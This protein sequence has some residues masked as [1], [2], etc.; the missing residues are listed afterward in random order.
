MKA[1][2]V[3]SLPPYDP[4]SGG[5]RVMHYLAFVLHQAG[6]NVAVNTR[7]FYDPSVPMVEKI[8]PED[9]GVYPDIEPGNPMATPYAM[10]W[11]LY[12]ASAHYKNHGGTRVPAQEMT[13]V[14]MSTYLEDVK[15]HCDYE[16][17]EKDLFELPNIECPEWLYPEKKTV[18]NVL[19][20][21][22]RHC[23]EMPELD[24]VLMPSREQYLGRWPLRYASISMLRKAK[25]LYT[26]DHHTVLEQEAQLCGC[27]VYRVHG[28]N[29]FRRQEWEHPEQR[30]MRPR[31]DAHYGQ[32]LWERALKFYDRVA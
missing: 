28:K 17:G 9:I 15:L 22:K 19:F 27:E 2:L 5:I 32:D 20:T 11:M 6:A 16:V 23:G 14:Y 7:C 24:Y 30:L 26:M 8:E 29:D 4:C 31:E 13:L 10:R 1:R 3:C 18:E 21:G 25:R 12:F